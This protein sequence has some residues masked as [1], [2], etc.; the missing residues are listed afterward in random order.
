MHPTIEQQLAGDIQRDRLA[1]AERARLV[2][3]TRRRGRRIPISERHSLVQAL[4]PLLLDVAVP[5]ASY[6]LLVALGVDN[7][8]AL[9]AGG[10]VPFARSVRS[11]VRRGTWDYLAVLMTVLFLVGLALVAFGG[12][13]KLLLAKE[14]FGTALLGLWCLG[15][16]WTRRP[17]TFYTARPLL[18]KGRPVALRCWDS[19]ADHSA[20]FRSIQRRLAIFWG[21][22]LLVEA[23]VRI[24]IVEH[25][26]VH[27][28][29]GLVHVAAV[30]IVMALCVLTGPLGLRLQRLLAAEVAGQQQE[31]SSAALTGPGRLA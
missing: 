29:A 9:I 4:G 16:A 27:T 14:S 25:Y 12:S 6:Y 2:H 19:L 31:T 11:V 17:M 10:A 3:A 15:S 26:S 1:R 24:G 23:A 5:V 28:A 13:P 18:T 30:G 8:P 20:P 22:G 21:L 7:T